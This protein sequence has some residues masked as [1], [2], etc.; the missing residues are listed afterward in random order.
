MSQPGRRAWRAL[1]RRWLK[2]SSVG[3]IGVGVQLAALTML[4][5]W[6]GVNY[7]VAT[8]LAVEAAVL[9]NFLWHERWTW[10][11]RASLNWPE[12]LRRLLRFN[13]TTG[14]VSILGNLFFMRLLVGSLHLHYL[15]ANLMTIAS[16]SLLNFLASDRLVF[17]PA[18]L[19]WQRGVGAAPRDEPDRASPACHRGACLRD[20]R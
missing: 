3:A 1:G 4:A 20:A 14:A 18:P 11:E 10:G 15:S 9:H 6:L 8:A 16:C 12:M 7:L 5:G 19:Q 2:F 13:L 17:Q